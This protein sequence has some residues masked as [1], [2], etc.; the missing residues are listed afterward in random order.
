MSV[1]SKRLGR[2]LV[3]AALLGGVWSVAT[4]APASA[5]QNDADVV[6]QSV[7]WVNTDY[8]GQVEVPW[9]DGTSDVFSATVTGY[10]T[11]WF[12]SDQGHIATAGHCL[13]ADQAIGTA[14]IA[15]VIAENDIQIDV[16]AN[17]LEWA[18]QIDSTQ[19]LVRQPT[20]VVGP[21][22]DKDWLVAQIV[23]QEPFLNGDN[24][25]LKVANLTGTLY[26]PIA[27]DRPV[28]G[29]DVV[30]VGYPGSVDQVSVDSQQPPSHKRGSVS[31]Y[32]TTSNGA[33][34]TEIDAAVSGG[35]SGGP[36]INSAGEVIGINS[37]GITG[38]TQPFNFVTDTAALRVFLERNGVTLAS[39]STAAPEVAPTSGAEATPLSVPGRDSDESVP[40]DSA[41]GLIVVAL[42]AFISLLFIGGIVLLVVY[43]RRKKP[44][45]AMPQGE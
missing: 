43:L 30:S 9:T 45:P 25:L 11:G 15:Q 19:V 44:A 2:L 35:M 23:A 1:S 33:P 42:V 10:C 14:L 31:S 28:V 8:T 6:N 17:Q 21:L 7:V 4:V 18:Y 38:E 36:T 40:G 3:I 29:D 39:G 22:S 34:V 20:V 41:L 26:L 16:P 37:F 24:A 13:E 32:T 12:V 5:S 27:A